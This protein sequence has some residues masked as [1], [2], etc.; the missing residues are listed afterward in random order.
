[1]DGLG[2]TNIFL[3]FSEPMDPTTV[4]D[5]AI[6]RSSSGGSITVESATLLADQSNVVLVTSAQMPGESYTVTVSDVLDIGEP[7]PNAI[8]PNPTTTNVVGYV[9]LQ[10]L[11]GQVQ[12]EAFPTIPRVATRLM[13]PCLLIPNGRPIRIM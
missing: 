6:T 7:V 5:A 8:D 11:A 10:C 3:T 12:W 2:N 1:M 9:A 4:E 13:P